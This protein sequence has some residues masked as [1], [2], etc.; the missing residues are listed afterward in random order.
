[1]LSKK[2]IE[3]L[4]MTFIIL[5]LMVC[6]AG[7]GK[8][9]YDSRYLSIIIIVLSIPFSH[10]IFKYK[11]VLFGLKYPDLLIIILFLNVFCCGMIISSNGRHIAYIE[12]LFLGGKVIHKKA[13]TEGEQGNEY[14]DT[15]YE[16]Q[17]KNETASSIIGWTLFVV[18]VRVIVICYHY[19]AVAQKLLPEKKT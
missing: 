6:V 8:L 14:Y 15:F 17:N 9:I 5:L 10:L 1:M 2:T 3:G 12:K 13:L 7:L 11:P 19:V 4:E 18:C 16:L